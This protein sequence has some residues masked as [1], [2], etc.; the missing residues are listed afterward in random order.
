[1]T[2]GGECIT[3]PHKSI[4]SG[5]CLLT[6]LMTPSVSNHVI[7]GIYDSIPAY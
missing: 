7:S 4:V 5:E 3:V 6:V 2:K 1:M